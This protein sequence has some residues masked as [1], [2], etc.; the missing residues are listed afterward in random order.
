MPLDDQLV[1]AV[2][3][4]LGDV[5]PDALVVA[6]EWRALAAAVLLDRL[7]TED[8]RVEVQPTPDRI[9]EPGAVG[10]GLL[11][12]DRRTEAG[13]DV[14]VAML[15][16]QRVAADLLLAVRTLPRRALR[17]GHGPPHV[18]E[19]CRKPSPGRRVLVWPRADCSG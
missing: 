18:V 7:L 10:H 9:G 6:V 11:A 8:P 1:E 13:R 3:L 17:V 5:D 12:A 19:G 14:G 15:A 16:P 4:V 2:G